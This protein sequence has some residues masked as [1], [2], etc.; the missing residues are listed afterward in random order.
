M[1]QTID[2]FVL[3]TSF[4]GLVNSF[5]G[6]FYPPITVFMPAVNA[7]SNEMWEEKTAIAQNNQKVQEDLFPFLRS[8]NC[9]VSG[10][11]SM[12]GTFI[13]PDDYA[14]FLDAGYIIS[15][16]KIVGA[17]DCDTCCEN[18][19]D[20]E[21]YE[22][23]ERYLDSIERVNVSKIDTTKWNACLSSYTKKPT[24]QKPKITQSVFKGKDG[25]L[26][27]GFSVS[28][29]KV[30]VIVLDYY[31]QPTDAV[32]AYTVS[33]PDVQTGSGEQIIYDQKNSVPLQWSPTLINEFLWRLAERFGITTKAQFLTQYAGMKA[34][35]VA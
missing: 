15:D 35:E 30:S 8:K 31:V 19:D 34:K 5:Q 6:G 14:Y 13:Q 4:N 24:M 32:F 21:K 9:I 11:N 33:T 16:G 17:S 23:V 18:E 25:V 1:T 10:N 22:R 12:F 29:R 20:V 7:I 28:P 2:V 27:T 3:W 26:K